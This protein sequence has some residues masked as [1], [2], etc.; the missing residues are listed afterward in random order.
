MYITPNLKLFENRISSQFGEDGVIAEIARCLRIER[1]TFFE[2]GIGPG[3]NGLEGCFVAL[4]EAGWNGVFLDGNDYPSEFGVRR[5][6]V[7]AMNVNQL[8]RKHGLPDD[9]DFM[10]ID[11]DGQ[12]FWIWMALQPRPR[13]MVIEFN[14][15]LGPEA[16]R[17]I[18]FDL[19]HVW[20]GTDY[21]GASL[22]ALDKLAA[23]KGYVLVWSNGVNAIFLRD[24]F[25]SNKEDFQFEAI[26]KPL[27]VAPHPP[28]PHGRPWVEI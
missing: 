1:G 11:V 23:A 4:R 12:E 7:T 16:S 5:E 9:L 19:R 24:D 15:G 3:P 27:P 25:V 10:S 17:T 21:H 8:Y 26:F 22:R 20:D 13:V 14:A 18:P 6:F 2:F 28:G